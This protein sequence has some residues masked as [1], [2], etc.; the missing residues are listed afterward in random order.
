MNRHLKNIKK[1]HSKEKN[2]VTKILSNLSTLLLSERKNFAPISGKS[3]SSMNM[4]IMILK[5]RSKEGPK[6]THTSLKESYGIFS[7]VPATPFSTLRIERP[8]TV[9]SDPTLSSSLK[10]DSSSSQKISNLT[11]NSLDSNKSPWESEKKYI[12]PPSTISS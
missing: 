11:S 2:L 4:L 3:P 6:I 1:E 7:S 5:E 8:H 10:K 9:M 12:S